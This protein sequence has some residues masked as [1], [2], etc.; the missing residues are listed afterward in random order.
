M[1]ILLHRTWIILNVVTYC[2]CSVTM[3]VVCTDHIQKIPEMP[4]FNHHRDWFV[5]YCF[6]YYRKIDMRGE[7]AVTETMIKSSWENRC[8]TVESKSNV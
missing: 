3:F 2:L 1:A 7:E 4:P 8:I 6:C 5:M